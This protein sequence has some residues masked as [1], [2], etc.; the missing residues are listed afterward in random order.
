MEKLE[1]SVSLLK[2]ALETLRVSFDVS[3]SLSILNN[4]EYMLTAQDSTIQRFEY[5]YDSFW[6]VLKR[7]IVVT[8]DI[9]DANSPRSVF[10]ACVRK[11]AVSEQEGA[12]LIDMIADRN[13]TTHSYDVVEIR[14]IVSRIPG[15]YKIMHEI[16]ERLLK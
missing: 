13:L 9:Q 11:K 12:V 1:L 5:C 16:T 6:K 7:Y 10:F 2:K 15:Y 4:E 3:K 8:Y 14:E